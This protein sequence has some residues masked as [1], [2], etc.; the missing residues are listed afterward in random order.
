[1]AMSEAA[2]Q[3]KRERDNA[4]QRDWRKRNPEKVIAIQA[5]YW[6]KKAKEVVSYG[7]TSIEQVST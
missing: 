7:T 2:K 1:M 5:R 3:I 4:Y 6:E